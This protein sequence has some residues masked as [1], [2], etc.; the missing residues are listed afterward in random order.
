MRKRWLIGL[1]VAGVAVATIG[2]VALA[3]ATDPP[4]NDGSADANTTDL[5]DRVAEILDVDA[6]ALEDAYQQAREGLWADKQQGWLDAL[7][8]EGS[9]TE[10]QA[11]EIE[12]WLEAIPDVWDSAPFAM[13]HGRM[14]RFSR[15]RAPFTTDGASTVY[16]KM[17]ESL[18]LD[19]EA[20]EQAFAQARGDLWSEKASARMNDMLADL[21]E[22]GILTDAEVDDLRLWFDQRPEA[23][24][25]LPAGG[26]FGVPQ[27]GM[28]RGHD[29]FGHGSKH[30]PMD[31]LEGG[32]DFRFHFERE[33]GAF[34]FQPGG[35]LQSFKWF[36]HNNGFRFP[37]PPLPEEQ[38][39]ETTTPAEGSAA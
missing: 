24:G 37:L 34:E 21:V 8:E 26:R 38:P 27:R 18:G 25:K 29:R 23:A 11:A 5:L 17:A 7:V 2:G 12:S 35:G 36:G 13:G 31:R 15:G 20:V 4:P 6:G 39:A 16:S 32:F 33:N 30:G 22:Q 3:D 19:A 10:D 9:L 14:H 1:L 28:F